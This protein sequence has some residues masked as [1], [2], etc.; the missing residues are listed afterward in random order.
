MLGNNGENL[1]VVKTEEEIREILDRLLNIEGVELAFVTRKDSGLPS[2]TSVNIQE[3]WL[4]DLS[5]TCVSIYREHMVQ[6]EAINEQP[7]K[8]ILTETE[9]SKLILHDIE[10]NYLLIVKALSNVNL[11]LL[12]TTIKKNEAN[13]K[14]L[15]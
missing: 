12:R 8:Q 11:G 1:E 2:I 6:M 13:L 15:I 3:E 7:P 4:T 9:K 10:E 14:E 5:H